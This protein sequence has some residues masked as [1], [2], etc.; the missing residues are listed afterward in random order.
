MER[1]VCLGVGYLV[2]QSSLMNVPDEDLEHER[3]ITC[4]TAGHA[5]NWH[6][7]SHCPAIYQ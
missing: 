5:E 3:I 2:L 7:T 6:N 1:T 4:L